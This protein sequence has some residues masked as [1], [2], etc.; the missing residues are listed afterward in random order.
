MYKKTCIIVTKTKK[1]RHIL[2]SRLKLMQFDIIYKENYRKMFSIA[3][4]MVNS[5]DVASDIVQDIFLY[6]YEKLQKGHV[7]EHPQNWLLRATINKC[8]DYSATQ[9]AFIR[10]DNLVLE[11]EQQE[12]EFDKKQS[13]AIIRFALGQLKSHEEL[14]LVLLYSEGYSYKEISEITG[15][16]F[17]S[18][19]KTLSRTLKKLKEI[20]IK[21]EM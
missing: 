6:Y 21:N 4:K 18:I 3:R 15:I 17:T 20:L 1:N 5:K 8:I 14:Q 12:E 16:K 7:V 11:E 2:I 19:G 13:E 10:L 9:K